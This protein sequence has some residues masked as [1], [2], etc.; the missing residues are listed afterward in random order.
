LFFCGALS[1]DCANTQAMNGAV[2]GQSKYLLELIPVY[3]L[4]GKIGPGERPGPCIKN[5]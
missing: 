1:A 5:F 4:V 2:P 3:L